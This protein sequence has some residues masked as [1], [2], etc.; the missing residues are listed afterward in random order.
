M[1]S[2]AKDELLTRLNKFALLSLSLPGLEMPIELSDTLIELLC[3]VKS[4]TLGSSMSKKTL[5]RLPS[6][7]EFEF[8]IRGTVNSILCQERNT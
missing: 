5:V 4:V 1:F 6:M 7:F 8:L 2:L 3:W